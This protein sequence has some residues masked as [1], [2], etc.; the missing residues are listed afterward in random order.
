MF[1]VLIADLKASTDCSAAKAEKIETASRGDVVRQG[2][3]YLVCVE[4]SGVVTKLPKS[5]TELQL[6]P[7]TTQGSRHI[8]VGDF[9]Y[10][11]QATADEVNACDKRF[12]VHQ[13]LVGAKLNLHSDCEIT[14]PEH[15]N[16]I[17]P[18]GS[19]WIVVY[20]LALADEI[21]RQQD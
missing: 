11:S 4:D 6:A 14:H 20:Q 1:D 15:G 2:D 7:G 17:L 5:A 16:K 12:A 18:A 8:L 3:L 9:T 19:S 10:A 21:R 13:Q